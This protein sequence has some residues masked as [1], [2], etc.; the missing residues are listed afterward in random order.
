MLANLHIDANPRLEG[1]VIKRRVS[2]EKLTEH[3]DSFR[4][5]IDSHTPHDRR[6]AEVFFVE[7]EVTDQREMAACSES[8][9]NMNT[10]NRTFFIPKRDSCEDIPPRE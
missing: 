4:G 2:D 7:R 6:G 1:D 10:A 9:G 8:A 3:S 5:A